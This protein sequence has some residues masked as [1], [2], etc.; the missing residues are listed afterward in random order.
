MRARDCLLAC[1]RA[2]DCVACACAVSIYINIINCADARAN[3]KARARFG[4]HNTRVVSWLVFVTIA[5]CTLITH[6]H[7]QRHSKRAKECITQA[8]QQQ[9]QRRRRRRHRRPDGR[10]ANRRAARN[11]RTAPPPDGYI[12]W[13]FMIPGCAQDNR[14]PASYRPPA[15]G[16]PPIPRSTTTGQGHWAT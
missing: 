16:P 6:T 2:C 1:V 3:A 9:K 12:S 14:Q 4:K 13:M 7:T 10:T 11:H 8:Q 5:S 15:R